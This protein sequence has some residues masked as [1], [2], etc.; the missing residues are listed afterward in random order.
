MKMT[1]WGRVY[2]V[3]VLAV[4]FVGCENPS[5]SSS[6]EAAPPPG[7]GL[8]A[9]QGPQNNS[10]LIYDEDVLVSQLPFSGYPNLAV[11]VNDG[12]MEFGSDDPLIVDDDMNNTIDIEITGTPQFA[13]PIINHYFN[14]GTVSDRSAMVK[15][16][17]SYE[18]GSPFPNVPRGRVEL[19]DWHTLE[20]S[21]TGSF[22]GGNYI[23]FEFF[24]TDTRVT[25]T[26]LDPDAPNIRYDVD[27][28]PGWNVVIRNLDAGTNTTRIYV[29]EIPGTARW[30]F[31]PSDD[32]D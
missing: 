26:G 2:A 15:T 10:I 21:E 17:S 1:H 7:A 11:F 13:I 31:Y 22:V 19:E 16:V 18:A 24:W 25:V 23:T 6:N 8:S 4:V 27:A 14:R 12:T 30:F 5:G 9:I 32:N 3:L 20:A 28:H 29:G